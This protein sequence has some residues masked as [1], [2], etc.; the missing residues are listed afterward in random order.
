MSEG[1]AHPSLQRNLEP[2]L[3]TGFVKYFAAEE[4]GIVPVFVLV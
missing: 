1:F 4:A 2:V 3:C